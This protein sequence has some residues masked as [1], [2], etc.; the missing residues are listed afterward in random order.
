MILEQKSFFALAFQ[1]LNLL[2]QPPTLWTGLK[3]RLARA[4]KIIIDA[5]QTNGTLVGSSKIRTIYEVIP[6]RLFIITLKSSLI[7]L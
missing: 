2:L 4:R 6:K 7:L 1:Q 3:I 5:F